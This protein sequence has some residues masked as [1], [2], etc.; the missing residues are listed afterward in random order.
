MKKFFL[1][2]FLGALALGALLALIAP[3]SDYSPQKSSNNKINS[4][5]TE[6]ATSESYGVSNPVVVQS[7]VQNWEIDNNLEL[8]NVDTGEPNGL[9]WEMNDDL[10][11]VRTDAGKSG[12]KSYTLTR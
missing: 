9:S 3:A 11:L 4:K 2:F 12:V 1:M 7:D 10:E 5:Y 6:N 8:I